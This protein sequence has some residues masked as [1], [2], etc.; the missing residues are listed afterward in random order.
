MSESTPNK[1][2]PPSTQ[3]QVDYFLSEFA[4]AYGIPLH[5]L[6][7]YATAKQLAEV[8]ALKSSSTT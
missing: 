1:G 6:L 5:R 2:A 3:D 4:R 7:G 8:R